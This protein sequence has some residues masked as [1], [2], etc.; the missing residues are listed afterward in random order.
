[1]AE[2]GAA[3]GIQVKAAGLLDDLS[4]LLEAGIVDAVNGDAEIGAGLDLSTKTEIV[5]KAA[6]RVPQAAVRHVVAPIDGPEITGSQHL[7]AAAAVADVGR[8]KTAFARQSL[9]R[10]VEH[11]RV[12]NR[13]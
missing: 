3:V 11:R 1:M 12:E 2:V 13:D 6:L 9:E 10:F 5:G 7:T 4:I 8:Q